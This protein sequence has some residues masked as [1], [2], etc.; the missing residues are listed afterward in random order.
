MSDSKAHYIAV[1]IGTSWYWHKNQHKDQQYRRVQTLIHMPTANWLLTKVL[2]TSIWSKGSLLHKCYWGILMC[3]CS[4]RKPDPYL[5]SHIKVN[6]RWIKDLRVRPETMKLL[7]ENR[8]G[9]PDTGV[10]NDSL[11]RTPKAQTTQKQRG[12]T[13]LRSFCTAKKIL[14]KV[15][16]QLQNGRKY[17]PVD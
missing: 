12:Y 13:E 6:S 7:E 11:D 2:G 4:R 10:G 1:V 17:M 8:R 14:K 5:T 9:I 3:T 15:K 16:R